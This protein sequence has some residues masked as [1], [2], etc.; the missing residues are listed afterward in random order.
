M[1]GSKYLIKEKDNAY[2]ARSAR[3]VLAAAAEAATAA[4][5]Q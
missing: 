5:V 3:A 2:L 1:S 4:G